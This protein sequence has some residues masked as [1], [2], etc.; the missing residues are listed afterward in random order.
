MNITRSGR[1]SSYFGPPP[2]T[3]TDWFVSTT[4][5]AGGTGTIGSPWDLATGLAGGSAGQIQPGDR[6]NLRAGTYTGRF[7]CSMSGSAAQQITVRPWPADGNWWTYPAKID[8]GGGALVTTVQIA[9]SYIDFVELELFN[10]VGLRK[11]AQDGS[12][13]TDLNSGGGFGNSSGGGEF[14]GNRVINCCVHDTTDG[15]ALFWQCTDTLI[16]GNL[17]YNVGWDGATDRGHGHCTYSQQDLN[18]YPSSVRQIYQN[19]FVNGFNDELNMGGASPRI[20]N[21]Y[22]DQHISSSPAGPSAMPSGARTMNWQ[23]GGHNTDP[24]TPGS[25]T[26]SVF[27]IPDG[28]GAISTPNF[29]Q[30]VNAFDQAPYGSLA[31]L[32]NRFFAFGCSVGAEFDGVF[33]GPTTITGNTFLGGGA[34]IGGDLSAG[35]FPSNTYLTSKPGSN[36]TFLFRNSLRAGKGHLAICNWT[37]ASTVAVDISSVVVTGHTYE[38]RDASNFFATPCLSGTYGGGTVAVPMTGLTCATPLGTS[39]PKTPATTAPEFNAF[40]VIQTN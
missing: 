32:N 39:V 10:S 17:V 24:N 4:G 13:P 33:N 19:L 16:Y 31:I 3:G 34:G 27:Y 28:M 8:N 21:M 30:A 26:N 29:F 18:T 38:I 15:I 25:I 36:E 37:G 35:S 1:R 23:T 22:V 20:G 40:V 2:V 5:S 9:C 7:T 11:S 14:R 12:S 6:L